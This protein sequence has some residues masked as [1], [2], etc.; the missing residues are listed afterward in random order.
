MDD[1]V[2]RL[3][4]KANEMEGIDPALISA[5]SEQKDKATPRY[6][7]YRR[8]NQFIR[9][10]EAANKL[11]ASSGDYEVDDVTNNITLVGDPDVVVVKGGKEGGG[12]YDPF[13]PIGK[14]PVKK[15][16]PLL[17]GGKRN[18]FEPTKVEPPV[19][20]EPTKVEPP[21]VVEPT[22]VEPPVVTE[23]PPIEVDPV[24]DEDG[25]E[26]TIDSREIPN[27][28]Y[29][30]IRMFGYKFRGEQDGYKKEFDTADECALY[31]FTHRVKDTDG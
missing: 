3:L 7:A 17:V 26:V 15:L 21:V 2:R 13:K 27:E 25:G 18:P 19:V 10:V 5:L 4:Y 16:D 8:L 28:Y 12:G 1:R 6:T 9:G 22:K 30:R 23:P 11:A 24:T 29:L 20:V 31:H 14:D